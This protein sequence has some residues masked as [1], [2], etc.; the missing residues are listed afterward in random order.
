MLIKVVWSREFLIGRPQAMDGM[1]LPTVGADFK[2]IVVKTVY[3]W[4]RMLFI[5]C[6][7]ID[8]VF[9]QEGLLS[10]EDVTSVSEYP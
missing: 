6:Q 3:L 5:S 10:F 8:I 2:N 9:R 1:F 7:D 4:A